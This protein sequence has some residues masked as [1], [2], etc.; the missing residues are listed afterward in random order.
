MERGEN[1][2]AT[3][4][5]VATNLVENSGVNKRTTSRG[6]GGLLAGTRVDTGL[7]DESVDGSPTT[8]PV[9]LPTLYTFFTQALSIKFLPNRSDLFTDNKVELD[10]F[11]DLFYRMNSGRVV[12]S[13]KFGSDPGETKM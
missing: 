6:R 8:N 12:F 1:K 13:T 2:A 10:S 9:P 11:F 7:N 5:K 3:R 4:V